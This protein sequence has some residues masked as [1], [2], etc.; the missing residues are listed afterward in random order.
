M[1]PTPNLSHLTRKDYEHVYEPAEDT[2]L[3]LDALEADKDFL[4]RRNPRIC[5]EIGSGSGCVSAFL[6]AVVGQNNSLYCCTDINPHA[7]LATQAT[8]Q[9]NN[10]NDHRRYRC[11]GLVDILIFNP[12]YVPTEVEEFT[13][14]QQQVDISGAWAGGNDGM[15]VTEHLLRQVK[16]LLSPSGCFYLVAV[17]QNKPVEIMQRMEQEY[18]LL[19]KTVLSRRAG[20]EHLHVL[21]FQVQE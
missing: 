20:R 10:A 21:R 16:A 7:S 15:N 12:P 6:G 1:I 4:R 17:S 2:F 19:S 14:G 18:G 8:G 3:L 5:L 9:Q 11:L 13:L